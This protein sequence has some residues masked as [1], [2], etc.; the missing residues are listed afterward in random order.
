MTDQER[1]A[2]ARG[3][4]IGRIATFEATPGQRTPRY[5]GQIIRVDF[6]G[7]QEPNAVPNFSL[8]VRGRSGKTMAIDLLDQHTDILPTWTEA[9]ASLPPETQP[10]T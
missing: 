10:T 3:F 5:A 8:T 7:Y 2:A 9:I 4:W 1:E 6:T